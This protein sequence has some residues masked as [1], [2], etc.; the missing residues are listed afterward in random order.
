MSRVPRC[1][2]LGGL[3]FAC[4]CYKPEIRQY[5]VKSEARTKITTEDLRSEFPPIPFRWSVPAEWRIAANDEFSKVAWSAGPTDPLLE[6]RITLSPLSSSAASLNAQLARWS[7]QIDL[8]I[9]DPAELRKYT[10]KINVTGAS[11][12]WVELQG[13]SETILGVII[14]TPEKIWI[15]KFRSCLETAKKYRESFRTFAESLQVTNLEK[16]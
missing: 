14:Q 4:G 7:D 11:G 5:T 10:E 12:V 16:E 15:F 13:P 6:A 9:T 8:G 1:A 2:V 3:I